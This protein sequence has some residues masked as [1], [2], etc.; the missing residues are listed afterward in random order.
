MRFSTR[1]SRLEAAIKPRMEIV[2]GIIN[3]GGCCK[4]RLYDGQVL[5]GAEARDALAQAKSRG[6]SIKFGVRPRLGIVKV[7]SDAPF[8][9]RTRL[10]A[11][12]RG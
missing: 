4:A 2:Y 3:D 11:E 5:Q 10:I 12:V 8:A 1:I 6:E 7:R 9:S